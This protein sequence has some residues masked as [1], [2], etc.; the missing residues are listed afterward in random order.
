M[1]LFR[2]RQHDTLSLASQSKSVMVN[3]DAYDVLEWAQQKKTKMNSLNIL[4]GFVL[5]SGLL[6]QL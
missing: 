4:E 6:S 1:I 3:N 2:Q 5:I